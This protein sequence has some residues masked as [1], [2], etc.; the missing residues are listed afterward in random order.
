MECREFKQL[1]FGKELQSHGANKIIMRIPEM[2]IMSLCITV[3]S[4]SNSA[5]INCFM[6][7]PKCYLSTN[8]KQF[9]DTS[10]GI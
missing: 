9:A 8:K 1:I 5:Y 6:E 2:C 3:K 7:E 10:P 4:E